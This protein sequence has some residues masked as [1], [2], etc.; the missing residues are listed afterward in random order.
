MFFFFIT[1]TL[2]G[3]YGETHSLQLTEKI[4]KPIAYRTPFIVAGSVATLKHLRS[5]GYETFP[6]MFD[7][8]YDTVVNP[9]KRMTLILRE[10]EKW[11]ALTLDQ[12]RERYQ[13]VLP[14]LGKIIITS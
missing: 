5:L 7:E 6:E 14:K 10:L 8:T 2:F 13:S 9:R 4:Y 1:E 11:R 3:D 12:K